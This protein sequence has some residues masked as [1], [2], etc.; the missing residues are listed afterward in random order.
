MVVKPRPSLSKPRC[1]IYARV[2]TDKQAKQ[3][4]SIPDQ[5]ARARVYADLQG[6]QVVGEYVDAG[7]SG[8]DDTGRP[9]FREML[10]EAKKK[11]RSFEFIV[12]HSF[13][14]FYRDQPRSELERRELKRNGVQVRSLTQEIEDDGGGGTLA[15]S[16][17]GLIDEY[18]SREQSKH[19]RRAME[20]NA[21]QGFR[22]GGTAPFGYEYK[23]AEMRGERAKKKL[24]INEAEAATVR[25]AFELHAAGLGIAKITDRLNEKGSRTRSDRLWAK[26]VIHAMLSNETYVGRN[27]YRPTDPITEEKLPREGWI[28]VPCPPIVS[29]ALF[30]SVQEQMRM[31]APEIT[32]PRLTTSPVLLSGIARCGSCLAPLQ[33]A[34]GTSWTKDTYRYY[35][36]SGK[37]R[38]GACAGG[39]PVSISEGLL[40]DLVLTTLCESLFTAD[41]LASIVKSWIEVRSKDRSAA[42]SRLSSLREQLKG[43][44][45]RERN[46]WDLAEKH[47]LG[48]EEDFR[49]R[50]TEIVEERNNL[51]RLISLQEALVS[52]TIKPLSKAEAGR[53]ASELREGIQH[54]DVDVRRRYV[55]AFLSCVV[56]YE[57]EIIIGGHN[58]SVAEAASGC[59]LHPLDRTALVRASVQDWLATFGIVGTRRGE[60]GQRRAS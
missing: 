27:Y 46:L 47:G 26:N 60:W 45:K 28:T 43:T 49:Q 16:V 35:K 6:W 33:L 3:N 5:M 30:E 8:R 21:R 17:M 52:E 42:S 10:A 32:A 40:D 9:Q 58:S 22:S 12:V 48:L 56:V 31:R 13:S 7:A 24:T 37:V 1:V 14:R 20:E 59:D 44:K 51:T 15:L 36:C 55:R 53:I 23:V 50:L 29:E 38:I 54:P 25:E 57:D 41:R 4:I 2:S 11:P 34:T 19:V 18:F 39:K